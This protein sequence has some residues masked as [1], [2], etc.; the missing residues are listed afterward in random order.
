VT[1][2]DLQKFQKAMEILA[3]M[4]EQLKV[5]GTYKSSLV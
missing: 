1:F 3:I 4:T 5:L 2:D